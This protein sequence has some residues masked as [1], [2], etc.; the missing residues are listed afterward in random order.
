MLNLLVSLGWG[1]LSFT[2][3][4]AEKIVE[5]M[6]NRGDLKREEAKKML[7]ELIDRG[8]KERKEFKEYLDKEFYNWMQ[9]YELVSREEYDKL[10]ERVKDLEEELD[11]KDD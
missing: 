2:K 4:K 5:E 1:T 7:N 9:K 3:E 8:E 11:K 10:A 6:V